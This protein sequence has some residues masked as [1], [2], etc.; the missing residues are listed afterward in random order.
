MRELYLLF[1]NI[2]PQVLSRYLFS[3]QR[4]GVN[5]LKANGCSRQQLVFCILLKK[6]K[7]THV[8]G[9]VSE[10]MLISSAYEHITITS[11]RR[12]HSST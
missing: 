2:F 9:T 10:S 1:M 11:E 12:L 6:Y 8:H 5:S 7:K 3:L 4:Q